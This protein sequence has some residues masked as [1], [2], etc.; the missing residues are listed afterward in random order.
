MTQI[1]TPPAPATSATFGSLRR[2]LLAGWA[3]FTLAAVG[4]VAI[5][6]TNAPYA[7]EWEFVPA[8]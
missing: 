4:F 7:D 1:Y 2:G 5:V 8:P 6:G 3:V